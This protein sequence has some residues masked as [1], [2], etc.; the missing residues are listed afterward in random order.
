M[1]LKQ[2]QEAWDRCNFTEE[3][4][5][6][7][8]RPETEEDLKKLEKTVFEPSWNSSMLIGLFFGLLFNFGFGNPNLDQIS[9]SSEN[10][11]NPEQ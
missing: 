2:A 10:K 6:L 5:K 1:D 9:E 4:I 7:F 3:Q 8:P 11:D